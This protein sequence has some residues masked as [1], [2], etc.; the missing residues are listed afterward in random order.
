LQPPDTAAAWQARR[1][2]VMAQL[3]EKV[4]RWFPT[5]KIPFETKRTGNTGGWAVRYGYA[6]FKECSF[7]SES[8]VRVR[9]QLY[10]PKNRP[11]APLL[12]YV[13]RASDSVATS[14]VDELLPLMGQCAILVL[15]P[16][17]TEQVLSPAEYADMERSS[18]WVGRTI[19]SMQVWDVL[20]AIDWAASEEKP[21]ASSI[22]V[23]GKGEMGIVCLYAGLFD[24]RIKQVIL[25]E[26]PGSH[27]QG[28]ALLNV[29]RVTDIPE[30]AG[31]LAPRR[32]ASLTGLPGSFEHTRAIYRLKGASEQLV[33][34]ASLPEALEVWKQ[35]ASH[36][37]GRAAMERGTGTGR[38][39]TASPS[40]ADRRPA[41]KAV[42]FEGRKDVPEVK[43]I[44][45]LSGA[46]VADSFDGPGLDTRTWHRPDWLVKNDPNLCVGIRDGHLRI[47]GVSRPAGRDH[48]YT[49][50][51]STYFRETDVVLSARIRVATSFDKPGR[52]RHLV[53]LCTGDWPD[54]FTEIDFGKLGTGPARW[55]CGY[56]DR[57]WKYSGY[58][59]YLAP[60]LPA[61][62]KEAS[63]W[64]EVAIVHDGTTHVGRNYL[65]QAGAWKPVGPPHKIKMNHSH[66]ELKVDVAVPDVR[67]EADFDDVRLYPSPA[68]HPV[69]VVVDSPLNRARTR[70]AYAIDKLKVRLIEQDS[71]RVL[72]EGVTD[73]G[74]QA[75]VTL[76]SD[77]IYPVAARIEICNDVQMLVTAPIR[78]QGI[79]GLY[80]SD[81]WVVRLPSKP[82]DG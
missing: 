72:G 77:V 6:D 31:A 48:Q 1:A 20:R 45:M 36:S 61:T 55:H 54:F 42:P 10:T 41:P 38:D 52:I 7:Q 27:W 29:L 22:A 76:R 73:E 32:L 70:P 34:A 37:S 56:V 14:D 18:V 66:V 17:L 71:K 26:P 11:G 79:R 19:A 74:G 47:S 39:K 4:F 59:E 5:E 35:S 57:I 12:I 24:E 25:N 67:V 33:Q 21:A 30:V 63:D 51:L 16:R 23:Y 40:A 49:G 44:R 62:G 60:T 64:H 3:R 65:I 75:E 15:N 81:V 28:P 8:K 13:K 58:G 68:R 78:R 50:V 9:A 46:L 53:H 69:T 2:T 82:K 80:P 43:A